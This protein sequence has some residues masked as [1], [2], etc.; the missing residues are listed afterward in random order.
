MGYSRYIGRVGALAAALG[1]ATIVAGTPGFAAAD[2]TDTANQSAVG[3]GQAP[4]GT[5]KPEPTG[6]VKPQADATEPQ[7]GVTAVPTPA[8]NPSQSVTLAKDGPVT[9][10]TVSGGAEI[11]PT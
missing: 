6:S 1:V 9:T 5:E 4:G 10:L 3:D 2:G 11:V 7:T 8:A